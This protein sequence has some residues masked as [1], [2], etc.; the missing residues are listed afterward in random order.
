MTVGQQPHQ[1]LQLTA[2]LPPADHALARHALDLY[3]Q[4]VAAGQWAC[5]N[6]ERLRDGAAISFTSRPWAAATTAA[7]VARQPGSDTGRRTRRPNERRRARKKKWRASRAA[8]AVSAASAVGAASAGRAASAARQRQQGPSCCP[9]SPPRQA[10]APVGA[11][12]DYYPQQ[13]LPEKT[14]AAASGSYAQAAA[15]AVSPP[16]RRALTETAA[17]GAEGPAP[18]G[19]E[20]EPAVVVSSRPVTPPLTRARK[21]RKAL[22]PGDSGDI[23]QLDGAEASPP[24][25]PRQ[26]PPAPASPASGPRVAASVEVPQEQAGP[27]PPEL[28]GAPPPPAWSPNLPSYWEQVICKF[29]LKGRHNY[30]RFR[31]CLACSITMQ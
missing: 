2:S 25:S 26:P 23:S 10:P 18:K 28:T 31:S 17:E 12:A 21:R 4:C 20:A 5:F 13:P 1:Q 3:A 22:S 6:V 19:P 14:A 29:C 16:S 24:P 7:R 30:S 11:G 8:S 9:K 27:D 15:R